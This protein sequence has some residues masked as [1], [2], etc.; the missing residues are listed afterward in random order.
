MR[1]N[2]KSLNKI[3]SSPE[4]SLPSRSQPLK[5]I[6]PI[7][8]SPN[9]RPTGPQSKNATIKDYS[10]IT[11]IT[12]ENVKEAKK[13]LTKMNHN[14]IT[15]LR[16]KGLHTSNNL[17]NLKILKDSGFFSTFFHSSFVIQFP[18]VIFWIVFMTVFLVG[19]CI[20]FSFVVSD[21]NFF[22]SNEPGNHVD[23]SLE[24]IQ[25][26]FRM[27]DEK[28]K[29]EKLGLLELKKRLPIINPNFPLSEISTLT[30]GKNEIKSQELFDLLKENDLG[31]Y[32][33][34]AE[35]FKILDTK[36]KGEIDLER[37][38]ELFSVLGLGNIDKKDKE[39]LMECLDIDKDGKISFEDFK[40]LFVYFNEMQNASAN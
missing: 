24:E 1:R 7:A 12:P 25:S 8:A 13:F 28:N 32:D 17:E 10:K 33:P 2:E 18:F 20:S 40:N 11:T 21:F 35:A 34:V 14:A 30:N 23:I 27:I 16:T 29:G 15:Q 37:I 31:D 9:S 26:V 3:E 19:D 38:V 36:N 39:I 5:P 6:P 22:E 4:R